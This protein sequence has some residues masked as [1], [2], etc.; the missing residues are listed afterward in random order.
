MRSKFLGVFWVMLMFGLA[1]CSFMEPESKQENEN[2][3]MLSFE[4]KESSEVK[5][6]MD[7]SQGDLYTMFKEVNNEM[8]ENFLYDDYNKDGIHEAFVI[9]KDTNTYKLW[10][11][12]PADCKIV[13]ENIEYIDV[14]NT[15]ILSFETKDY[16]LLQQ[17][18]KEQPN[19]LV[20]SVN[21]ENEVKQSEISGM[22]Y[23]HQ[24]KSGEIFLDV[25]EKAD[26]KSMVS[27]QTYNTYYLYYVY[28]AGFKEYGGIP[29]NE[30][31]FLMFEGAQEILDDI[32]EKYPG[33]QID[34]AY[35]YRANHYINLNI[36]I[37][38]DSRIDYRSLTLHY[39]NSEVSYVSEEYAKGKAEVAHVLSIA[40][41]P[42]AFKQPQ[43]DNNR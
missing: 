3:I 15:E 6:E 13:I 30:E 17:I 10:Y 33:K 36:T 12:T 5:S 24:N 32:Y 26:E 11:M 42:T 7:F 16:L 31:Q 9:T 25:Y 22:G 40:T 8:V 2:E 23:I 34:I 1:G 28:D 38:E 43:I 37:Y 19:T 4:E 27:Q 35:L 29:I 18:Q 39:D 21:N 20:Y 14:E 41:F